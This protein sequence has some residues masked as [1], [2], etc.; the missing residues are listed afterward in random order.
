MARID[1]DLGDFLQLTGALWRAAFGPKANTE[2]HRRWNLALPT[3]LAIEMVG[4][5]NTSHVG[6][7]CI[8]HLSACS[9]CS[10]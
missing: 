10:P 1:A 5:P 6:W 8:R 7:A 2:P 3:A 9:T 4:V